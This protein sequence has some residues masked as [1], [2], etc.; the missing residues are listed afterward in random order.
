MADRLAYADIY[1]A[2]KNERATYE[3]LVERVVV[4]LKG[5]IKQAG[6]AGEVK[7]R[8]KDLA[9]FATKALL[10]GYADPLNE[11]GDIAGVRISLVYEDDVEAATDL[12]RECLYVVRSESKLDALAFNEFGYLGVHCDARLRDGDAVD[13]D[14][15]LAD[16]RVEVQIRTLV[17]SAWAEVSHEKLYK[18]AA[19]VPDELKRQIYRLV[20]L[21]ELFDS[22]VSRFTQLAAQTPGYREAEALR[23]LADELLQRFDIRVRPDRYLSLVMAAALLPLYEEVA[24]DALYEEVMRKWIEDNEDALRVQFE[25][26]AA[27]RTNPLALQPESFLIFERLTND[28][29]R[30]HDVWP[31]TIP[32]S[33]Y[34]ELAAAWGHGHT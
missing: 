4:L 1:A 11:I 10:G 33:W 17:Q 34:E 14:A 25:E 27:L 12:V 28:Q 16:R 8:T 3:K 26:A 20:A 29:A 18:P 5:A 19:G 2:F 15:D 32:L 13:S 22:E 23:P 30:L 6:I 24:P 9:S 31:E 7:G 21:V